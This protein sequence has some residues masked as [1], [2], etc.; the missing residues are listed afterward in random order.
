[1]HFNI[2]FVSVSLLEVVEGSI[3]IVLVIVFLSKIDSTLILEHEN[4]LYAAATELINSGGF[5]YFLND[6]DIL[7]RRSLIDIYI[8]EYL[9]F[10]LAKLILVFFLPSHVFHLDFLDNGSDLRVCFVEYT[11]HFRSILAVIV[12]KYFI[13]RVHF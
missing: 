4:R 12:E 10:I 13:V 1:M 6:K 7:L 9:L 2:I 11:L 8:I 5:V 3:R